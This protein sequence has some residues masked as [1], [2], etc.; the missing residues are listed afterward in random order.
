MAFYS[1]YFNT[2]L[3]VLYILYIVN[4]VKH[5][6]SIHKILIVFLYYTSS[7]CFELVHFIPHSVVI[8]P[9]LN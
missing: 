8:S 1:M 2:I 7:V 5:S 4:L 3:Y 6:S 9:N